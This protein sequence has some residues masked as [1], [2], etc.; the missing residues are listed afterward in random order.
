MN[1]TDDTKTD[2]QQPAKQHVK[3]QPR[4]HL[5]AYL[6]TLAVGIWGIQDLYLGNTKRGLS[7]LLTIPLAFIIALVAMAIGN[8]ASSAALFVLAFLLPLYPFV[9][10][11]VDLFRLYFAKTDKDGAPLVATPRDRKFLKGFFIYVIISVIIIPVLYMMFIATA[12]STWQSSSEN[13]IE[14]QLKYFERQSKQQSY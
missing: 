9:M 10:Y 4:N 5:A 7:R 1:H 3:E 6:M 11:L 14:S 12:L 2:D 13:S 8:S